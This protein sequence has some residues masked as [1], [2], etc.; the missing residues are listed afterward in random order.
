M[1]Q[2]RAP[3]FPTVE[4]SSGKAQNLVGLNLPL[5][6]HTVLTYF[7]KPQLLTGV[8]GLESLAFDCN[9]ERSYVGVSDGRILKWQGSKLG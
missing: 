4:F 3:V 7:L 9:G 1:A 2:G 6:L 5:P 8:I